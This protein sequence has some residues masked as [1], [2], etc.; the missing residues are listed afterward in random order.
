[1][2]RIIFLALAWVMLFAFA[3]CDSSSTEPAKDAATEPA[4]DAAAEPAKEAAPQKVIEFSIFAGG[5]SSKTPTGIAIKAMIAEVE[6]KTNGAVKIKDFYDTE[7]GDSKTMVQSLVQ[8]TIDFGVT[9]CSYYSGL[10]PQVQVFELPFL[11]ENIGQA[12]AAV[13]GPAKDFL[14]EKFAAQGIIGLSFWENG[15]RQ[16]TNNVHPINN[17]AD[18]Q[19]IKIRTL[20]SKIQI[21]AWKA[22]GALPTPIDAAELYTALH[23]NT[24]SAQENPY[25]VTYDQKFFE[26]QPYLTE[27][28]HV[29]TP[30]FVSMSKVSA[31]RLTPEQLQIIKDAA[32]HAQKIQREATDTAKD[33]AKQKMIEHGIKIVE[34]IDLTEFRE[35]VKPVYTMFTDENGTEILDI[36]R[37]TK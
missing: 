33:T 22:L 8:G 16:L 4:K 13:D 10:V 5:I 29:Y 18:L 21:E 9:G 19:G 34:Q 11:F 28:N 7:L 27:T 12:R 26:V 15:M 31:D 6:E 32:V 25:V 35:R 20:P 3:G 30:F 24:V 2:K 14:F 1:M 36:V 17:L 37:G 23:V